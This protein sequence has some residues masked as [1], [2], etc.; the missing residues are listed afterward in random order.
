MI[1]YL[2][3]SIFFLGL[4]LLSARKNAQVAQKEGTAPK[5]VSVLTGQI[6]ALILAGI[7]EILRTFSCT[8]S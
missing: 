2:F 4:D 8:S 7:I 6:L 3:L 1:T 5:G